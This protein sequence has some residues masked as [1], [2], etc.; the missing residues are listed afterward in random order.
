MTM[1]AENKNFLVVIPRNFVRG[2]LRVLE[3]CCLLLPNRITGIKENTRS[4]RL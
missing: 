2:K 1:C 4:L 3:I